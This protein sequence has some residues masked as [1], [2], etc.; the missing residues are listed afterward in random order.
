MK[1][2]ISILVIILIIIFAWLFLRFVIGGS[3]DDWI[4]RNGEWIK[5]G[6]PYAPMPTTGCGE[7][8]IISNFNECI[9]A[10][11]PVMESYPRQCRDENGRTF[12]EEI[13]NE[14]EKM[15]LIRID[16]P[17]PNQPVSSPLQIEGE[18]RGYW[19]FEGDFPVKIYDDN[20][21]LLA[22][23]IATAQD[24]WMTEGFVFFTSEI[25]FNQPETEKGMLILERDNPSG[26]PENADQLE[27]PILFE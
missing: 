25:E 27:V 2:P 26:L 11:N 15:D 21:N 4:C 17:R 1:K 18:A 22:T 19:F 16:L 12:V 20:D 7:D 6:V 23:G 9:S 13:G 3:E 14:L 10:G 24:E 5:H 8:K